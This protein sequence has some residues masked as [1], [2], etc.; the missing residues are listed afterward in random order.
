ME[1]ASVQYAQNM[2]YTVVASGTAS[3]YATTVL[4]DPQTPAVAGNV[5]LRFVDG[6]AA[7]NAGATVDVYVL[8]AGVTTIPGGTLPTV[9]N[10]KYAT[11]ATV[12]N[13][14]TIDGNG[15]VIMP[16][17][18]AT[19]FSVIFTA[20][21]TQVPIFPAQAITVADS[22]FYTDVMWDTGVAPAQ[23]ATLLADRR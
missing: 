14:A 5:G 4:T 16:D 8:A 7:A 1:G 20:A 18:G 22:A 3:T 6:A 15:Y 13:G 10:L 21:G 11:I 23:G 12:A 19:T 2:K 17:G 9:S